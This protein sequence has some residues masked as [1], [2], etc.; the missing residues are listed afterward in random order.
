MSLTKKQLD[1]LDVAFRDEAF[2]A[3]TSTDQTFLLSLVFMARESIALKE[4][5]ERLRRL[6]DRKKEAIALN[7]PSKEGEN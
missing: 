4:E 2:K 7:T 3:L 6:I 1:E 5:N